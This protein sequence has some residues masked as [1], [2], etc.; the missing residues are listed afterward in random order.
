MKG[1]SR[2]KVLIYRDICVFLNAGFGAKYL[3]SF[4]QQNHAWSV[5][6]SLLW[7]ELGEIHDC[8]PIAHASDAAQGRTSGNTQSSPKNPAT[9]ATILG[10]ARATAFAL[11]P[12]PTELFVACAIFADQL[13]LLRAA[14]A[15]V[16]SVRPSGY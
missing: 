3:V 4:V 5:V 11:C 16:H 6:N 12:Q 2:W 15:H 14:H 9:L 13:H 10:L 7:S 1:C 8:Q